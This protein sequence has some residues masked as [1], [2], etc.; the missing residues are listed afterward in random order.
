MAG[1]VGLITARGGSKGVPRKNIQV[2]AGKPLIA[3][4]IEAALQSQELDRV[5][6]STDDREIASI[7]R[8]YGAEVPFLRPLELA[9][10]ASS[11]VDVILHAINWLAQNEQYDTKY[12]TLLQP[13]SPFRIADD[14]DG[15]IQF[16]REKNA[17]S[18]IGMMEAPSHPVCLRG[19]NEEGL[20]LE[21]VP[22]Q[23]ESALRRQVLTEVYAFNGALYVLEVDSFKESETFRPYR[24]TYGYKMPPER[25]WEIDTEWEFLVA[26]LLMENQVQSSRVPKAA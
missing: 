9:L 12:I 4:T 2:L 25:S 5:I 1:V 11:H 20:L 13:T 21:L 7:S 26:S 18:V 19:M 24:E 23:E 15:A 16:A 6:V 17:K 3:W 14:I 10:D 22:E 8:R